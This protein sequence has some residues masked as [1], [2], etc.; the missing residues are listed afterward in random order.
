MFQVDLLLLD[1][2]IV[3]VAARLLGAAARRLGQPPVVGEIVA[4]ILLGP[5]L[6]GPLVGDRLFGPGM[7]PP[8]QAL[9][10]VGLVL[11]MFV[12]G[13]ELDQK[14][15]RGKGR[16]AV[17]IA[18]GSTLLPFALGCALAL[19]I[20]GDHVD[21][22]RTLPFV[23][24][25]GA[26]MAA[27]AFPVLARVITDRGMQRVTVGGLSL[28][29]AAVID[30]LAWTA[31]AVV[32]GLAS[33]D[34]GEGQWKV[35]LALPYGL[36]MFLVVRPL[37]A[38]L[39]PAWQ[40]A[41][42]LT[43]GL[44]SVV[45]IG[46]LAS[47]WAT[48]WMHVHF[49]FG[50]FVFGAVMPREGAERLNHE[51]L[52]R[53][54][55]LAV[56]LLLPMFFVVAGLNV[57][58]RSLDLSSLGT[59]AAIL[60]VAIGGKLVGSYVAARTQLPGRQALAIA[61]LLNTRGLTEIVILSVGL[62]KGVLDNELY[63][64]MVVMALLTTA[65][66]GPV[67]R[68]VYPERRV[69]RDIT[70]AER[71]ALGVSA[72]HRVLVVVP[73]SPAEQVP[74]AELAAVLARSAPPAKVILAH[75][76]PY[77]GG[78][79]ELGG[80]LSSELAELAETLHDLEALAEVVRAHGHE[81]RVVSRFSASVGTEL[82]ELA[83]GASPDLVVLPE[84]VPGYAEIRDG[85]TCPVVTVTSAA[86]LTSRGP[87]AVRQ[88]DEAAVRVALTLALAGGRPLVVEGGGRTSA[89][90]RRLDGLGVEVGGGPVPED[91][92]TVAGESARDAAGHLLVRAERDADPVDWPALVSALREPVP[93]ALT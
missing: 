22:P 88:A 26:A 85:V 68:R 61:T 6:L 91:A 31:L 8:L 17:V 57:D 45:L 30:V 69:A 86:P 59:L 42:R 78:R 47:S 13:M 15:V 73:G 49:I 23:L 48:E 34:G 84:G 21:G 32:V 3:L 71:E 90:V 66:T 62:Q 25:M 67:L 18:L 28:A 79:L 52:E 53:L 51:I 2:V 5:T 33:A 92:L 58:L 60:V 65:M 80:G 7:L 10:D 29:S 64:L 24:F 39:V 27:T 63:S 50:A 16:I 37:L 46:L 35:A 43:P 4:G 83:V 36:V 9:A 70:Q 89:L 72:A 41:G 56:L 77:P 76:R 93:P 38:R 44:L 81:A 1:L 19:G 11:F 40:R 20:A 55:Q 12:V 14:L 82:A 87:V 74:L 75:L 54:E